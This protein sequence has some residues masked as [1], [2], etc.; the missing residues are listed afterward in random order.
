MDRCWLSLTETASLQLC[1]AHLSWIYGTLIV[2]RR[3]RFQ[4]IM[5]CCIYCRDTGNASWLLAT[6]DWV[7]PYCPKLYSNYDAL[8]RNNALSCVGRIIWF[9]FMSRN[10]GHKHARRQNDY[11]E[12]RS[13]GT[14]N[15]HQKAN[16]CARMSLKVCLS[17]ACSLAPCRCHMA[18]G[19]LLNWLYVHLSTSWTNRIWSMSYYCDSSRYHC[20]CK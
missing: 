19:S 9:V 10:M 12:I 18:V 17:C 5:Q 1:Q 8:S 3:W 14:S 4:S 15:I 13:K 20:V 16:I 7:E 11:D 2:S 6:A